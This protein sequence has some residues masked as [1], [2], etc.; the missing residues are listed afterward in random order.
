MVYLEQKLKAVNESI[1][2]DGL[3]ESLKEQKKLLE[4]S[5][6][7]MKYGTGPARRRYRRDYERRLG[8]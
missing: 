3:L 8:L 4:S 7:I 1:R 6:K 2:K 5:I